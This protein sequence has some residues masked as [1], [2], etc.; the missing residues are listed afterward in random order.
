[1]I[2][3][4]EE[5]PLDINE[6]QDDICSNMITVTHLLR[7]P[8]ASMALVQFG[9]KSGDTFISSR[10]MS[11]RYRMSHCTQLWTVVDVELVIIY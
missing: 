11:A 6:G 4:F 8:H 1:M 10:F 2:R 7:A 9:G 5:I 3:A